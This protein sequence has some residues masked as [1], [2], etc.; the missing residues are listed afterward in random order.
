MKRKVCNPKQRVSFHK[1]TKALPKVKGGKTLISTNGIDS[2]FPWFLERS[3]I[4]TTVLFSAHHQKFMVNLRYLIMMK[5]K[6]FY[7][8]ETSC[9]FFNLKRRFT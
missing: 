9:K 2:T 1:G 8:M 7:E 3:L 4:C 6:F 5:N